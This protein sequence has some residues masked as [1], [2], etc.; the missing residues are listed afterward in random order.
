M[1]RE[2]LMI[3][4][5]PGAQA[6]GGR[7]LLDDRF[8]KGMELHAANWDGPVRAILWE[9]SWL[10]FG[11]EVAQSDLSAELTVLPAG[12]P[13][14]AGHIGGAEV[15][16]AAADN[17]LTHGLPALLPPDVPLVYTVEYT[18]AT[19][20]DVLKLQSGRGAFGKM[21]SA[22]WLARQELRMRR[23]FRQA[24]GLQC[25]GTPAHDAYKS[26]VPDTFCYHDGRMDEGKYPEAAV[27]A[28]RLERRAQGRP[29]RLVNFGRLDPI[30]GAQDLLPFAAALQGRG[31][32]FT[33]D[34]FGAGPL[35]EDIRQGIL[36]KGLQENVRLHAPVA[37]ETELVP[38]LKQNA[39][40]FLSCHRQDDP[41]CA[42]LE[43][44]GC[45]LPVLGYGNRMLTALAAK[46]GGAACVAFGQVDK[47]AGRAA[48]LAADAEG[49]AGLAKNALEFAR[50]NSA[51][52]VFE[53]RMRH[54]ARCAG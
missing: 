1:S 28:A 51:S 26:L 14:Q 5:A 30:K 9:D 21:K 3:T 19:R 12:A 53:A 24:A 37:F 38:W 35:E 54:L 25:N 43:A 49:Y 13:L 18:L 8:I 22:V 52:S 2:L 47:L 29:L 44:M 42:Y 50:S 10:P 15:V 4:S 6:G 20:L 41:S 34:I 33:L 7:F 46:S 39:D 17:W 11:R 45:G 27:Q 31:A 40:V 23:A 36:E 32:D 48:A 16:M